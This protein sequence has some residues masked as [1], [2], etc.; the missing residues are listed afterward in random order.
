MIK[1][2]TLPKRTSP[3]KLFVDLSG[4]KSQP[5]FRLL[6]YAHTVAED[7]NRRN[8]CHGLAFPRLEYQSAEQLLAMFVYL[9]ID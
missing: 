7:A 2:L 5:A 6:G 4:R 9:R 8:S 3:A 1:R